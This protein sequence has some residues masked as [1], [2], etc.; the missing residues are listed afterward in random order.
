LRFETYLSTEPP[1]P[2]QNA[3]LSHSHEDSGRSQSL[4]APSR[5]GP[6]SPDSLKSSFDLSSFPQDFPAVAP[7][8]IPARIRRR[9][10]PKHVTMHR[11]LPVQW[12]AAFPSGDHRA[13]ARRGRRAA[14]SLEAPRA[15]SIPAESHEPSRGMGYPGESSRSGRACHLCSA[16][17]GI[18]ASVSQPASAGGAA[19]GLAGAGG[20]V[21]FFVLGLIRFYQTGLSPALPSACRFYPSCSAYAYE[22]VEK[23]GVWKGGRLALGRLLRCRPWGPFG[24]DPVPEKPGLGSRI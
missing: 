1:A 24:C 15:R 12:V 17:A 16:P 23:W 10:T 4:A 3:R 20:P 14:Q 2:R 7:K 9:A 13:R 5:E 6:S 11:L 18:A 19:S 8:R 21:K 22:A